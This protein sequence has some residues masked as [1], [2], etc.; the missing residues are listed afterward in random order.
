MMNLDALWNKYDTNRDGKL[1]REEAGKL[2]DEYFM[3]TEKMKISENAKNQL[4]NFIDKS[5]H[6]KGEIYKEDLRSSMRFLFPHL[7]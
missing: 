1:S 5:H 7:F 6:Y 2:F 3:T 4:F